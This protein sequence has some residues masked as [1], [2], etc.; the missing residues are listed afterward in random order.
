M[1]QKVTQSEFQIRGVTHYL[2]RDTLK[3]LRGFYPIAAKLVREPEN[4]YDENAIKIVLNEPPERSF[5]V[6]YLARQVSAVLAPRMDS[7]RVRIK[8]AWVVKLTLHEHEDESV[9]RIRY[10]KHPVNK[11]KNSS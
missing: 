4:L 11:P 6:G 1:S 10:T 2:T 5:H 9:V 3:R 7:G 8:S